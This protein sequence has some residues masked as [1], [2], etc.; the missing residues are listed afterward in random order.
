MFIHD[1][2]ACRDLAHSA[3]LVILI[4]EREGD[5]NRVGVQSLAYSEQLYA[6]YRRDPRSVPAL[7]RNYLFLRRITVAVEDSR[8]VCAKP[9]S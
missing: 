8:D 6:D 7:G 3:T 4:K 5:C 2:T 9:Y 1:T